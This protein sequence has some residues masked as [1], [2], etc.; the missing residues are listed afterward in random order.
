VRDSRTKE[1]V[2]RLTVLVTR[3]DCRLSSN[4]SRYPLGF[5]YLELRILLKA[6]VGPVGKTFRS[7]RKEAGRG[8]YVWNVSKKKNISGGVTGERIARDDKKRSVALF[9]ASR[10]TTRARTSVNANLGAYYT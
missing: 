1:Q 6:A 2:K 5:V 3:T 8:V 4:E 7:I 9:R 10:D